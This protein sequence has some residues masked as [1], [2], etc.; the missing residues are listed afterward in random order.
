MTSVYASYWE[1]NILIII[2]IKQYLKHILNVASWN[3]KI[4]NAI[5]EIFNISNYMFTK[6][7]CVCVCAYV[8]I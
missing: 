7:M 3:S 6:P 5:I 2:M 4:I 1:R 8:R